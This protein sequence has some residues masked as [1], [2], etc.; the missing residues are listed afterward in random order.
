MGGWDQPT[1][2]DGGTNQCLLETI[3]RAKNLIFGVCLAFFLQVRTTVLERLW[4]DSLI[5]QEVLDHKTFHVHVWCKWF[6]KPLLYQIAI[7]WNQSMKC[8]PGQYVGWAGHLRKPQGRLLCWITRLSFKFIHK[9]HQTLNDHS[10]ELKRES[11]PVQGAGWAGHLRKPQG[12]RLQS[13]LRAPQSRD[14]I[15][16]ILVVKKTARD[17]ITKGVQGVHLRIRLVGIS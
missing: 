7:Q 13:K 11:G 15:R 12:R 2:W 6:L 4:Y 5:S 9:A 16:G 1:T 8:R 10:I 17:H 3:A 14:Q